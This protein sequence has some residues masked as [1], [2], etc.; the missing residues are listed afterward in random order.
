MT[1]QIKNGP[2]TVWRKS[3]EGGTGYS[4]HDKASEHWLWPWATGRG[5]WTQL[6]VNRKNLPDAFISGDYEHIFNVLK[7]FVESTLSDNSHD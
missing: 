4:E 2:I 6:E 7:S 5:N 3:E 1:L